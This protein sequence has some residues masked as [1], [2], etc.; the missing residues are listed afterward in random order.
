MRR[1]LRV[2]IVLS[3]LSTARVIAQGSFNEKRHEDKGTTSKSIQPK[4][5]NLQPLKSNLKKVPIIIGNRNFQMPSIFNPVKTELKFKHSSI[6]RNKNASSIFIKSKPT[7]DAKHSMI[8]SS[9]VSIAATYLSEIAPLLKINDGLNEFQLTSEV[10]DVL[11]RTHF[12]MQQVYK[13][14][15][16]YGAEVIVHMNSNKNHF[17]LNG[18]PIATPL[19]ANVTPKIDKDVALVQIESDL[20]VSLRK[21]ITSKK[22]M[23]S[24]PNP[25]SELVFYRSNEEIVLT[26]HITVHPNLKDRWEYFINAQTGAILHKYYNT[27]TL[28]HELNTYELN[29]NKAIFPPTTGTGLDLNDAFREVNTFNND[30][31][32]YLIDITRP[33]YSPGQSQMPDNPVGGIMTLDLRNEIVDENTNIYH[34]T[35]TTN[36]WNNPIA[37]SAHYNAGIAYDYFRNTFNRNSINGQGG[38]IFSLINVVDDDGGGLDNAYWNGTYMFYGNGRDAFSPLAGS[39]DVG[40]HEMS[41]GVIQNT[42]NLVYEYQSGAINESFADIFGTMIDREDWQLGEDVVSTQYFSSGALRDMSNPNNGGSQLGDRGWQPKD[43]TEYYTGSQDNGGVHINSGI[44]NKA[45]YLYATEIG[46][47]KAEQVYYRT[48]TTYLTANSQFIDLRLGVIESAI[49]LYGADSPEMQAAINA[50]NDVGIED[51]TA[52]DTENEI[53]K[54][55]GSEFILSVDIREEDPNTLYISDTN[56]ENYVPLTTTKIS[57]KPSVADNGSFAIYV[58]EDNTINAVSLDQNNI[59]EFVISDEEIWASVSLSKDGTRLAA[60]RNDIDGVIFVSDI[61]TSEAKIFELYNPTTADGVTTGEILYADALEW[62]YSGQYLIYDALNK[63]NNANGSS[64][65]YWDVGSLRAWNNQ[66]NTF[67]DGNIQKIFT[68]LPEGISIGNPSFAKTSGNILAFDLLNQN[69]DTYEVITANIETGEVK[70]VYQNN[71]IGYPNYSKNDDKLLFDTYNDSDE[72]IAIISLAA[73]KLTPQG[74]PN[75]LIPNGIWGV[76][77]TVGE[78]ETASSEKEI[79][80]FRFNVTNPASVGIISGENINISIPTNIN[81]QSLI[82]T[83]AHSQKSQVYIGEVL[84]QSGVN[85]NDFTNSIDYMVVAEDGSTKIFTVTLGEDVSSNSNDEDSDGVLNNE[86]QC[87]NTPPN[88]A[89]NTSGCAIFSL[90]TDNFRILSKG[91]SCIDSNNGSITINANM[92]NSYIATISGNGANSSINFTT[93]TSFSNLV[94]GIYT[95]CITIQGETGFENCFDVVVDQ[96]DRLSVSSKT[97]LTTKS[98]TFNLSGGSFYTIKINDEVFKTSEPEITVYLKSEENYVTIKTDKDCQGV[99]EEVIDLSIKNNI[100]PNPV[101]TGMITVQLREP[102]KTVMTMQLN[103]LDGRTI[104]LKKVE[105]GTTMVTLDAEILQNGIYVLSI[106]DQQ[107]IETFK[108]IKQ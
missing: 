32:N 78:R 36:A 7:E 13:G 62:D 94:G 12:K 95:I 53:P 27:C 79:T 1:T 31:V 101:S 55:T 63:L 69:N 105:P 26:H 91:E 21:T 99:F 23:I 83:F 86:D 29:E 104:L 103:T 34:V 19:G 73:D 88:T 50:F 107:K 74:S 100:Y 93:T 90:P 84:Q 82:A 24:V 97:N 57:K 45:Y 65:E 5:F 60:V 6:R 81:S 75:V 66:T 8:R 44:V 72:D 67:G 46:K 85:T 43:M 68:N 48:L 77:Y 35:N 41:H 89:V 76:W 47:D 108:I 52:T 40:G 14:V 4:P 25:I 2:F 61:I 92:D 38:T 64:I 71:K 80:D 37:I 17:A 54:V 3:F 30:G 87:P 39:L 18:S 16:V 28:L 10:T 98:A 22:E 11:G 58:T 102:S 42:A 59:E 20:G 49:D 51:G 56:G 96:P 33:M 70:T 106:S 9:E 15:K